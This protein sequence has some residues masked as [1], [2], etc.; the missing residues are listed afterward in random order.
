MT[1]NVDTAHINVL[2]YTKWQLQQGLSASETL[3][4]LAVLNQSIAELLE[5]SAMKIAADLAANPEAK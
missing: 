1:P 2:S 5:L 3:A 4:L